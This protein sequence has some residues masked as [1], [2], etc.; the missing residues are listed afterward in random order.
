MKFDDRAPLSLKD[1]I[2]LSETFK[3]LDGDSICKV[4]NLIYQNQP[5]ALED[6]DDEKLH[7]RVDL[8]NKS[9]FYKVIRY[10]NI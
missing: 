2:Q 7:I 9:L 5:I 6:V 10:L 4:V 8:I 3:K 1:K